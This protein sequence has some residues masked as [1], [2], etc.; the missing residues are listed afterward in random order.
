MTH[1]TQF[2]TLLT[3]AVDHF[4]VESHTRPM[5]KAVI[6][7]NHSY[8][9]DINTSINTQVA[10]Q[11]FSYLPQFKHSLRGYNYPIVFIFYAT[12][13]HLKGVKLLVLVRMN[14]QFKAFCYYIRFSYK[15]YFICFYY[16]THYIL[17]LLIIDLVIKINKFQRKSFPTFFNSTR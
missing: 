13:F 11:M 15:L 3:M 5:C 9:N 16:L 17:F 10:E 6:R 12:F 14:K 7:L 8:H 2:V 4:Y 1:F